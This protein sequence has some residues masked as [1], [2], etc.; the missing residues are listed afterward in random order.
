MKDVISADN[1]NFFDFEMFCIAVFDFYKKNAK[2]IDLNSNQIVSH[3]NEKPIG[4][5]LIDIYLAGVKEEPPENISTKYISDIGI[6]VDLTLL[7]FGKATAGKSYIELTK[8]TLKLALITEKLEG[9]LCANGFQVHIVDVNT[10]RAIHDI[11]A[12]DTFNNSCSISFLTQA[13]RKIH[14]GN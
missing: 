11:K 4:G 8:R 10:F 14:K 7:G 1:Y 3:S 12:S 13:Y 5:L 9:Y 6:N 2:L